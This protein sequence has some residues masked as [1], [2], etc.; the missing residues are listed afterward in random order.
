MVNKIKDKWD[1]LYFSLMLII[2]IGIVIFF[3]SK[4]GGLFVDEIWTFNLSNAYYE[5]FIGNASSYFNVLLNKEFFIGHLLV[6][7]G[8]E[9]SYGSVFYNQTQDVHPPL[10]YIFVHTLCSLVKNDN[11]KWFGIGLNIPFFI[12]TQ[13]YLF[14]LVSLIGKD[15]K[16]ALWV[17]AFYGFSLGA[18]SIVLF[19]RM[20]ALLT[21]FSVIALY[22]NIR[23]VQK[24]L[25]KQAFEKR[26]Y[27]VFTGI[28]LSYFLGFLTQYYFLIY[29]FFL[30]LVVGLF[31]LFYAGIKRAVCYA[32]ATVSPILAGILVF[33]A[34]I[35]HI[36]GG[37]YR[38][39]EAASNL[40]NKHLFIELGYF[41]DLLN[42]DICLVTFLIFILIFWFIYFVKKYNIKKS[43]YKECLLLTQKGGS[44]N[45]IL[46]ILS[47]SYCIIFLNALLSFLL[48]AKIAAFREPRYI[49]FL[50]PLFLILIVVPLYKYLNVSIKNKK[51][52]SLFC[53]LLLLFCALISL[54]RKNIKWLYHK[55]PIVINYLKNNYS[56]KKIIAVTRN[57]DWYPAIDG[58]R[59][60]KEFD[61]TYLTE[62]GKLNLYDG[63]S[64]ENLAFVVDKNIKNHLGLLKDFNKQWNYSSIK[65]IDNCQEREFKLYVLQK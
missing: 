49:Y 59:F 37:G 46:N 64:D 43:F 10:Y 39:A 61:Y 2:Q 13:Y 3:G 17:C 44:E 42:K 51:L 5:P 9:F 16:Q 18:V 8:H 14:R 25:T 65:K 28:F 32:T 33:P 40:K 36:I 52:V 62:P 58:F 21:M 56:I 11:L 54:H 63:T 45:D 15:K 50:Y 60:F 30:S 6:K 31:I 1:T 4:K 19:I 48:I 55:E 53:F 47:I 20:Y 29:G 41:L 35:T 7:D 26:D 22:Y 57:H 24:I 12:I 34:S 23:L 27:F 38:G